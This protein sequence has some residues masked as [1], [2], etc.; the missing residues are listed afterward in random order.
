MDRLVRSCWYYR[1][2]SAYNGD[3][4][5]AVKTCMTMSERFFF[6]HGHSPFTTKYGDESWLF[7]EANSILYGNYH[8]PHN[9]GKSSTTFAD[10]SRKRIISTYNSKGPPA[11]AMATSR[12]LFKDICEKN[13]ISCS[14]Y[15]R[16]ATPA[17]S[18]VGGSGR[19]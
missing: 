9:F 15:S 19:K 18:V 16:L 7:S 8:T 4:A 6:F 12:R 2:H 17:R 3:R 5:V 11:T 1:I 13:S 14:T 10:D